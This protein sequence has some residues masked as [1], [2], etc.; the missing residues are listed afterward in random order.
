VDPAAAAR[1]LAG[2]GAGPA[3]R[4]GGRA[5]V[6][7]HA[8]WNRRTSAGGYRELH[9]GVVVAGPAGGGPRR[10]WLA[11]PDL[12]LR[13]AGRRRSGSYL[14]GSV[15]DTAAAFAVAPRLWGGEPHRTPLEFRLTRRCARVSVGSPGDQVLTL[16]GR[17]GPWLP[18]PERDLVGYAGEAGA[19]L[20]SCVRTRGPARLHPVPLLRLTVAPESAHPLAD[21]LRELG[22]DGARP[23]LCLTSTRRQ[24]LR[25]AAVPISAP[26]PEE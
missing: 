9:L 20:R 23:L 1:L 10:S 6:S 26:G 3:L 17:L 8:A 11:W 14:A 2:T 13:G 24:A 5:L 7:V 16:R 25:D 19:T 15:V 18:M 4:V 21:R 22:L 12:L